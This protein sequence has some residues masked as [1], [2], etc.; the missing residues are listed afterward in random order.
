MRKS[1]LLFIVLF[2]AGCAGKEYKL[3]PEWK[4]LEAVV[5]RPAAFKNLAPA[6][7]ST[8]VGRYVYVRDVDDWLVR[9]RPGSAKF[10]GLLA[11][12][13]EHSRRQLKMGTA[14]WI[15]K[16]SIDADFALLEEQIGYYHEITT[17]RWHGEYVVPE[18]Y[19]RSISGYKT[20]LGGKRLISY[21]DA[22]VWVR[23]VLAGRWSP[24]N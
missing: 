5:E 3:G 16:Y 6:T 24:P 18:N 12:E 15:A 9:Y 19:A 1:L 2:L 20:I 7:V 4:P 8:T 22:L 10:K 23:D 17:R 13:Q 11:H 14:K 21:A